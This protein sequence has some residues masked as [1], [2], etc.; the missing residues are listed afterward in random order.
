MGTE[1]ERRMNGER[2]ENE[3]RTT[4]CD[5]NNVKRKAT[6]SNIKTFANTKQNTYICSVICR[7]NQTYSNGIPKQ[8]IRRGTQEQGKGRLFQ[9]I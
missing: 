3:R 4:D 5:T 1:N 8:H 9:Q 6:T 7:I 2:T